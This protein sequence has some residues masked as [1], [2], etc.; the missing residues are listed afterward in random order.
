M[1]MCIG[2]SAPGWASAATLHETFLEGRLRQCQELLQS[3]SEDE[4]DEALLLGADYDADGAMSTV[5]ERWIQALL[6]AGA[7]PNRQTF[8]GVSALHWAARRGYANDQVVSRMLVH[9]GDPKL[10]D[11]QGKTPIDYASVP[12]VREKLIAV[13]KN[14]KHLMRIQAEIDEEDYL[15]A[16]AKDDVQEVKRLLDQNGPG[17]Q[18]EPVAPT[19]SAKIV[20]LERAARFGAVDVFRLLLD[21][22]N[23]LDTHF[24]HAMSPLLVAAEAGRFELVSFLLPR[25]L[26]RFEANDLDEDALHLAI[27]ALGSYPAEGVDH[28]ETVRLLLDAGFDLEARDSQ[29]RTP[30][31]LAVTHGRLEIAELLLERGAQLEVEDKNKNTARESL[32][33]RSFADPESFGLMWHLLDAWTKKR[34]F[35]RIGSD[36]KEVTQVAKRAHFLELMTEGKVP[37]IQRSLRGFNPT[38]E[39]LDLAMRIVAGRGHLQALQYLVQKGAN[40]NQQTEGRTILHEAALGGKLKTAKYIAE[41]LKVDPSITDDRGWTAAEVAFDNG[42]TTV[43]NFLESQM[44]KKGKEAQ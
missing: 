11:A 24:G 25:V 2:L 22:G 23:R 18:M 8:E 32:A 27:L 6:K 17:M 28:L 34:P 43:Q 4:I 9:G 5:R 1:L 31:F 37:T 42:F 35:E 30:L 15:D 39:D 12:F 29:G 20:P 40:P 21:R 33:K 26:N 38:Q 19:A 3:A 7:D 10:E 16:I 44:S 13:A 41:V 14:P 36:S